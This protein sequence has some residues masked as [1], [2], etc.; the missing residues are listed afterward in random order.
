M[1]SPFYR[2]ENLRAYP[3]PTVGKDVRWDKSDVPYD[4][5]FNPGLTDEEARNG[6]TLPELKTRYSTAIVQI[7]TDETTDDDEKM[8][9][10][11]FW[12]FPAMMWQLLGKELSF[13]I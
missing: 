9:W 13:I 12:V 1:F 5:I 2:N 3:R 6:F 10:L 11:F 7:M 4:T 8:L